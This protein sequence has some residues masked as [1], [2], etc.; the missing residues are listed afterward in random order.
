MTKQDV[1]RRIS[2]KTGLDPLTTRLVTEAFFEVVKESLTQS[3]PVYIRQFGSF[4]LKQRAQKVGRHIKE[5]T[6][7]TIAAHV[8][9]A[10]KQ[11][12]RAHV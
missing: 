7:I 10:F 3:E 2:E 9:P 8:I 5:N 6:T 1:I 12:G 11:I 4:I